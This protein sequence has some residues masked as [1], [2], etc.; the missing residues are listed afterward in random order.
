MNKE[1]DITLLLY[2]ACTEANEW[3]EKKGEVY[4]GDTLAEIEFNVTHKNSVKRGKLVNVLEGTSY[5][6]CI[7]TPDGIRIYY[8]L[9]YPIPPSPEEVIEIVKDE[10]E[11]EVKFGTPRPVTYRPFKSKQEMLD[12][13]YGR[14][15]GKD[16]PPAARPLLWAKHVASGEEYL[17]T[18]YCNNGV[19]VD[20]YV[21]F[22]NLLDE[23][24]TLD[25]D[26]FGVLQ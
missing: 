23:Y 24:I 2:K 8:A 4:V 17:I 9:A 18:G 12:F 19:F 15:R 20:E 13:A 22:D 16:V 1:F 7:E 3:A 26:K 25:G 10:T 5:P 14:Q 21:P 6:F 11:E